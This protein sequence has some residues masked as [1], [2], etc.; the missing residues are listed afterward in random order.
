MRKRIII[1][2]GGIA[3]L[4]AAILLQKQGHQII[5]LDK[6]NDFTQ[7][8]FLLSLKSFGVTIMEELGL[9]QQLLDASAPSEYMN[10]VDSDGQLIRRVSYERMNQQIN[11]SI[12]LITRGGLHHLLVHAIQDKVTILLDTR[13]E[14]VEQIGQTV[15]AT[16]SNGQ[17][18]EADLLLVSEGLRST[19]RNRY[20]AGSHVEDFNVFYMGGRLNEPH[21]YPVGSFKTFI[22][23]NKSLAIYPISSD[24][25][26]MQC[27]IYNTDEV[28]QLQAKTDQLLTET[29][30]GYGSEVQQLIDRFLHHG[31]LFSDKMGMA[32]APNLVNN[33]IVLVGDAG[34][35]PTALS[36]M[37]ASLSLYGAK[38]LAHFISQSP[39]EISLACQH[40]NAL[41]Q[42]IIEKF[43]R[44]ARSNAE[45]FLPQ[46][47]ASLNAFTRYFST[48]SEADLY[49]RMTAQLVL[50]DD[51]LHF[52][53]Q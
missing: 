10:F 37:G 40:Y 20:I 26:A 44:N 8:G 50:T 48:A 33:R 1:S 52:F 51:Q 32:H 35:C 4:A 34:Y 41:M 23:V 30:K 31:L 18:I 11:Q 12:R 47:E 46:N 6:V 16:L 5:V 22:D 21:T 15:K 38:A 36:G 2:G 43:Q 14:Q 19:T 9:G 27:Y 53:Y 49:Q 24:E 7:A 25:L 45:T 28:A 17:L 29:F 3:G 39:D 13:L 42:P